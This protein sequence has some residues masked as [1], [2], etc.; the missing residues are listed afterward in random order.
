[1]I[2]SIAGRVI[3]I[4]N[5]IPPARKF[6]TSILGAL[7][8]MKDDDWISLSSKFKADIQWFIQYAAFSKGI[9]L[10]SLEKQTMHIECDSIECDSVWWQRRGCSILLHLAI[11]APSHV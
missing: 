2:Q 1:M 4:A 5:C 11:S 10:F 9:Y 8:G 3:Y 6:T 7:R